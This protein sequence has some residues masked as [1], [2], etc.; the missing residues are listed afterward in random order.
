MQAVF[1]IRIRMFCMFLCLLDPHPDPLLTSTD[2]APDP[3]LSYKSVERTEMMFANYN[4]NTKIFLL[5]IKCNQTYFYNF[6]AFKF[7]LLKQ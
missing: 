1:R 3:F 4:F 6:E 5:K 2:P 7:Y